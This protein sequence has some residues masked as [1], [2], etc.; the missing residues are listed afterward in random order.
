MPSEVNVLPTLGF[1]LVVIFQTCLSIRDTWL[2]SWCLT[3]LSTI[4]QLYRMVLSF[5]GGGNLITR[6]KPQTCR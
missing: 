1:L 5:T 4:F 2:G 3:P 6:G